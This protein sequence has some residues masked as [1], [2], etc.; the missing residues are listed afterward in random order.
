MTNG[1][2]GSKINL[3]KT[4]THTEKEIKTMTKAYKVVT[5]YELDRYGHSTGVEKAK[6]FFDE[7][8]AKAFYKK[9]E[10]TIQHTVIYTYFK[11]GSFIKA[12]TGV[13]YYEQELARKKD[14]EKVVIETEVRNAFTF[15][16]IEIE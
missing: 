13:Q 5:G 4:N 14:N 11:D 6:F 9:G 15:Q 7:E 1:V 10:Y 2:F 3:T 8:K 12:E 16:E